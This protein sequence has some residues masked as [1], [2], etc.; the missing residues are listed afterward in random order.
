MLYTFEG[1]SFYRR[2]VGKYFICH[3]H[4]C[5]RSFKMVDAS[6]RTSSSKS[7]FRPL[8]GTL[9]TLTRS[10]I[11]IP[12]GV[13][14]MT[15][16]ISCC[17]FTHFLQ[18]KSFLSTILGAI[19]TYLYILFSSGSKTTENLCKKLKKC[20]MCHIWLN[21]YCLICTL[22]KFEIK[23]NKLLIRLKHLKYKS[24]VLVLKGKRF[25][26]IICYYN[27]QNI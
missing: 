11:H 24:R 10:A 2:I 22:N 14:F 27:V 26:F 4:K 6:F 1:S 23:I 9:C 13:C 20:Y 21:I 5:V 25:S 8:C 7:T 16:N 15:C 12:A 3:H 17:L 18:I 19:V